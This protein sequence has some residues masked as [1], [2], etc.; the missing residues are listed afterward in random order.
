MIKRIKSK[1]QSQDSK[2][3]SANF[4]YLSILQGMN[5]LLPLITFPYLVRVLGIEK[6]GLIMF[7]Q[8]FIVYFSM[9]ADYGFNLS[10]IRE[11][12]S[13]RNNKNKLIK[14]FSSIM[15]A[16]IV[17]VLVGLIFLSLIV[18]S[19]ERFS[20]DWELYFLTFGIVIGTAL[21]P[22]WFFQG[23]EKMK[24]ITILT[25]VAKLIFTISIFIFVQDKEDFIYV[26][27]INSLGFIFVGLISLYIIF[28]D[29]DMKFQFQKWK[30][31]KIQFIKGWH[32]FISKISI[33]L[34]GATNTFILGIFTND[35]VVGYYSIAEKIVRI[36]T[37]LFAPFYQAIYPH[38][39]SIVKQ[40]KNKAIDFLKKV[41]KYSLLISSIV[42]LISI[43]LGKFA[44][45][46]VF[47][48][49]AL[50]SIEIFYILSPL[51]IIIPIAYL[52]F[53]V[54]LLSYKLDRYFSKLYLLGG[55]T[56][57]FFILILFQ[58]LEEKIIAISLSLL[59]T[60]L[61]ITIS[62]YLIIKNKIYD[63]SLNDI[64]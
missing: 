21:F 25:V 11:V 18:F 19:F 15:T 13:N 62:A 54:I 46:L 9:L 49:E 4:M 52:F 55:I 42:F 38:V 64:K 59:I 1:F 26:P 50:N 57:I 60:E 2:K 28:K 16:R 58:L 56:N 3:I 23:M 48:E 37:S 40:P 39:I 32:I 63:K 45:L 61:L 41:L 31:I 20:K 36:I 33:N 35:T 10:G 44:L 12:S 24:Y 43:T 51:I 34:Y 6:F 47:G 5:L 14:I 27:V 30:R 17:L 22:T 29:F 8:A 53:N 7:A